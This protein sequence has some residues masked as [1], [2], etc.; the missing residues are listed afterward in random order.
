MIESPDYDKGFLAGWH[1][2]IRLTND[3]TVTPIQRP[4]A[5]EHLSEEIDINLSEETDRAGGYEWAN[6][7]WCS[8]E[9]RQSTKSPTLTIRVEVI[10]PK[11]DE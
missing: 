6:P 9:E 4:I 8:C 7:D 2:A 5:L 1:A 10:L 3:G 11:S